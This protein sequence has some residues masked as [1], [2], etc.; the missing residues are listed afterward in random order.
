MKLCKSGT[1]KIALAAFCAVIFIASLPGAAAQDDIVGKKLYF[2]VKP[3]KNMN[4]AEIE[5]ASDAGTGLTMFKYNATSSR[6]G[7]KGQKF[8]G[9]MV[10]HNPNT[11]NGTTTTTVYVVPLIMKIGGKTFNPTVADAACLG[12]KVPTT[13]LKNS[14]MVLATHDFKVNGVDV[15]ATQYSDAF[16]R[17]EF[18]KS[19]SANGGTYH[20]KLNYVFL[21]AI[22][23]T[24]GSANSVLY[25]V[26][27]T[28]C[29]ATYGGVEV[30]WLD[31][32]VTGTLIPSLASKGVG[33]ANLPIF[34]MY[35][36][37]MYD[38][39]PGTCC[40][41]G[42]HGTEST[43]P[44]QTY[45]PFQFDSVGV[46]TGVGG[47][48]TSIM[49]HEVNEWQDDPLGNNPTPPW[50]NIGQVS[51]CQGNLEVGDALTG[52]N[53][54]NVTM[55]GFTYHLQELANFKWFYGAPANAAGGKFSDN[56][57]FTT[58]AAACP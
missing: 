37:T 18:W 48:D 23:V 45:S 6:T 2:G 35:N 30:N 17:G 31:G 41:G 26:T 24:P 11:T 57:T 1:V 19:V 29:R 33:P 13:V 9:F 43:S 46:F 22:T 55:N 52:T 14:P 3:L 47:E 38:S 28:P 56:G 10:G 50:G 16:R 20:N 53:F 40:I 44:P 32:Y 39:S 42:Y 15:G 4:A 8:S 58:A 7:S 12:G 27:G 21:A 34:M 36:T 5:A 49:S 51:G 25:S 54:P